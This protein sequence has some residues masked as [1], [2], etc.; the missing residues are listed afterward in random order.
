[1]PAYDYRCLNCKQNFEVYLSYNEYN[2]R[3][4]HCPH[5]QSEQVQ[6][7]IGRIR[8]ARSDDERLS[9]IS[10]PAKFADFENDPRSMGKMMRKMSHELG[11]D[12]GPE[13][14]EMVGRLEA[15][16]S[17][18]EIESSM[19]ELAD[20]FGGRSSMDDGPYEE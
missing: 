17:P 12:M 20:Q 1:M 16:Q 15:G 8:F 4:V 18:E 11:E 3:T 6:R 14:N 5:C 9:D 2:T 19:P 10:D 13:F 7:R